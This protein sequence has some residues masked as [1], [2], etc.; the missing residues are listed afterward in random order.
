MNFHRGKDPQLEWKAW[1]LILENEDAG[2][3]RGNR[4][5]YCALGE[6]FMQGFP[7]ILIINMS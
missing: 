5:Y 7:E 4:D 6:N 3:L 1:F 2:Y